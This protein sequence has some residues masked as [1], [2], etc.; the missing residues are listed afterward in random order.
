MRKAF[1][2]LFALLLAQLLALP[3]EAQ[4]VEHKP[5]ITSFVKVETSKGD[6]I[7]G[8]YDATPCHRDNFLAL[9]RKNDYD[10]VLFH[11]VVHRF[12]I[13]TGNLSTKGATAT[14]DVHKDT[15][16]LRLAHEIMPEEL[17]HKRG[18][19]GAAR[20]GNERNPQKE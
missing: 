10:G 3:L 13:Q 11:R 18:A 6:F 20:I 15:T 7:I 4:H 19:I 8:L 2:L 5:T 9:V 12:M 1:P 14:S 16:S 17:F